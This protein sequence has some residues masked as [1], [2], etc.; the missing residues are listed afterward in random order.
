MT[1]LGFGLCKRQR[2][3][4]NALFREKK[5]IY[6]ERKKEGNGGEKER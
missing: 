3:P 6:I 1:L 2:H 5:E 4:Q